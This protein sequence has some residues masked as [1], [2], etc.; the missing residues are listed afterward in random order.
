MKN[1]NTNM[2]NSA[3]NAANVEKI[4]LNGRGWK[5][6]KLNDG[7]QNIFSTIYQ[8]FLLDDA[9]SHIWV[10]RCGDEVFFHC[11]DKQNGKT[12][13]MDVYGRMVF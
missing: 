13:K 2:K 12:F 10:N 11:Y 6:V 8:E 1:K 4:I 3:L 7:K 5:L 9:V